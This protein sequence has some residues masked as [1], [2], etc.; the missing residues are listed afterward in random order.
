MKK[1]DLQEP[2]VDPEAWRTLDNLYCEED[3]EYYLGA[4]NIPELP[5]EDTYLE[6]QV[7]RDYLNE[8][9]E[10]TGGTVYTVES[11]WELV[12]YVSP[13]LTT[14][15]HQKAPFELI[16]Q[17]SSSFRLRFPAGCVTIAVA[18]IMNYHQFPRNYCDWGLVNRYDPSI[19]IE[20]NSQEV[21]DEVALLSK[22]VASGCNVKCNYMGSGGTF[23]TP[24]KAKRFLRKIGYTGTEKHLGYD[25]GVIKKTLKNDCPV[26]IGALS[27]R[28]YGHAW[29]LDGYVNYRNTIK[30]YNGTLLLG[31]KTVDK[32]FVHCNWGWMPSDKN[33][34]Y[35]SKVFDTRKGPADMSEY[36][37]TRGTDTRNYTWWFRVVTYNKPRSV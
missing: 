37:A 32:L 14:K 12:D 21:L 8:K 4:S 30:T 11:G 34:Y 18:Q 23:S 7:I 9:F 19:N 20:E 1:E 5:I 35:A 27:S 25:A 17:I 31:T 29:V 36:P 26:F 22:K 6:R 16:F 15:W 2:S 13:M 28:N 3:D 24:A 33:G 10:D